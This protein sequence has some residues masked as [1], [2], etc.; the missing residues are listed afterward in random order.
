MMNTP[1][2]INPDFLQF[3]HPVIHNGI[4]NRRSH[5][6][7]SLMT[8]Y[9]A[10][11]QRSVIQYKAMLGI[12]SEASESMNGI[13]AVIFTFIKNLCP[14]T[15]QRRRID[16]PKLRRMNGQADFRHRHSVG[17]HEALFTAG[18]CNNSVFI[19]QLHIDSII[20]PCIR[21]VLHR[22][23]DRNRP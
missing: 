22:N 21:A 1:E 8:A 19:K 11:F 15:V 9:T 20:F 16:I 10:Y 14:N 2:G 7:M 23:F 6:G 18:R 12:C 3:P 17:R 13:P 5:A 4:R